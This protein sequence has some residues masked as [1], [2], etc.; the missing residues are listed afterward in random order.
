[1]VQ[2]RPI[3]RE[4]RMAV[5]LEPPPGSKGRPAGFSCRE[6]GRCLAGAARTRAAIGWRAAVHVDLQA[7]RLGCAPK[8]Y[9]ILYPRLRLSI[10]RRAVA[11]VH[12]A[13]AGVFPANGLTD[14]EA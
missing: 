8:D 3:Q 7:A 1:M 2:W 4:P 13:L 14:A 11:D 10:A 9:F 5:V 6:R 12:D